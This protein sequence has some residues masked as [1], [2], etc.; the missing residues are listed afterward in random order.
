[1]IAGTKDLDVPVD[2][3]TAFYEQAKKAS[4]GTTYPEPDL[5]VIEDA[6]HYDLV[7]PSHNAWQTTLNYILSYIR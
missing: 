7:D 6:D 1:M 4:Q 3:V 5:I 2:I